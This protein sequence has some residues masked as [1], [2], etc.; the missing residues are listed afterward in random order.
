MLYFE[1]SLL[2]RRRRLF[3]VRS[4]VR[5]SFANIRKFRCRWLT[6]RRNSGVSLTVN[7]GEFVVIFGTSGGGKTTML[8]LIGTI[9]KP[10]KGEMFLCGQSTMRI[11]SLGSIVFCGRARKRAEI[12]DLNERFCFRAV[13][14]TEKTSDALLAEIRLKKMYV[15]RIN[16]Q[17]VLVN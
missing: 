6:V 11:F 5:R 7:S 12:C 10:T 8:N 3:L 15:L 14:I 4:F 16:P 9:D 2:I 1:T 17:I 13:G